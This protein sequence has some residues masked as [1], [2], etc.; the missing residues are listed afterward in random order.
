[1]LPTLTHTPLSPH[2]KTL[3]LRARIQIKTI[4]N[5]EKFGRETSLKVLN[6]YYDP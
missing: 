4:L 3:Q 2:D 5:K 1:M 6:T